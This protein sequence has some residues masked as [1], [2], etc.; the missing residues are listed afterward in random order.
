[1]HETVEIGH[2]KIRD[3]LKRIFAKRCQAV[4]YTG[5]LSVPSVIVIEGQEYAAVQVD[6]LVPEASILAVKIVKED[7]DR[8]RR[9]GLILKKKS[10]MQI[11][12]VERPFDDDKLIAEMRQDFKLHW[13]STSTLGYVYKMPFPTGI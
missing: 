6:E 5:P 8:F 11:D 3:E 7:F 1:M 9:G 4:G 10:W 13:H 12:S 2:R